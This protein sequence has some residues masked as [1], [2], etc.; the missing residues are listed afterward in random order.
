MRQGTHPSNDGQAG[1]TLVELLIVILIVGILA[2]IAVPTLLGQRDRGRDAEA[3]TAVAGAVRAMV[4]YSE[5]HDDS[6]ECGTSSACI[7]ALHDIED[8]LPQTGIVYSAPG[9][10]GPPENDGYRVTVTGG[11]GR[12]FWAERTNGGTAH[13]CDLNG[14]PS[15]GGCHI[16]ADPTG[17]SW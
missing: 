11:D 15:P 5:G 16:G 12:S 7:A 6:Y 4:I 8:A 9:G 3:K 17:G 14:A 2:A 13:G 10:S 1:F